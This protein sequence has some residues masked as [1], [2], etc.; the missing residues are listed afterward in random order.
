MEKTRR[1]RGI[2]ESGLGIVLASTPLLLWI[3]WTATIL[4]GVMAIAVLSAALLVL[5]TESSRE[6]PGTARTPLSPEFI[7]EVQQLFPLTY[8]HSLHETQRFRRAMTQ[9]SRLIEASGP[10]DSARR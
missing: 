6:Q 7:D 5:L 4:L 1:L 8:H 10:V 9:M 2:A 3:A